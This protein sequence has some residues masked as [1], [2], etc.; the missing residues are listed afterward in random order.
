MSSS[1]PADVD[2]ASG[3][4]SQIRSRNSPGIETR[5][6]LISARE[7]LTLDSRAEGPIGL[8][9]TKTYKCAPL[10]A[11]VS[12]HVFHPQHPPMLALIARQ[13]RCSAVTKIPYSMR[14]SIDSFKWFLY[15]FEPPP[16]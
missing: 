9:P 13:S 12:I 8:R 10:A 3:A 11:R 1:A 4:C 16:Q 14:G 6:T 2:T 5:E 7:T 15:F